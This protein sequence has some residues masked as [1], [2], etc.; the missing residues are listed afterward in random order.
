MSRA[1]AMASA[2]GVR[3]P[4]SGTRAR[5]GQSGPASVSCEATLYRSKEAGSVRID[6]LPNVAGFRRW[7]IHVRKEVAG[8]S[9]R[10]EEAFPWICEVDNDGFVKPI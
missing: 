9:G 4:R 8:G 10:P 5:G 3:A 6:H 2:A 7:K 1:P